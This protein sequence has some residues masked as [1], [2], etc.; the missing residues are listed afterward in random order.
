MTNSTGQSRPLLYV[1]A[2]I[3]GQVESKTRFYNDIVC[4]S[5]QDEI[6][7]QQYTK[8]K[9]NIESYLDLWEEL[10]QLQL[11]RRSRLFALSI[12]TI[13][14]ALNSIKLKKQIKNS[15]KL[16]FRKD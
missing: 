13:S 16:H 12:S 6:L 15:I 2:N 14:K 9:D 11:H 1:V 4:A 5:L 8:V 3:R 7:S 10:N